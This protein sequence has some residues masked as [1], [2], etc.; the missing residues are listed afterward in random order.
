M[1][2]SVFVCKSRAIF[3]ET[4]QPNFTGNKENNFT[5]TK[6]SYPNLTVYPQDEVALIKSIGLL[7]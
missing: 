6:I 2:I 5:L 3:N 4:K 1:L 7:Y